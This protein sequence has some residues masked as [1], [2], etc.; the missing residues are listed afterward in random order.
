M[1]LGTPSTHT[2]PGHRFGVQYAKDVSEIE[3]RS[4]AA[5]ILG[6]RADWLTL[7]HGHYGY[8]RNP[9][10]KMTMPAPFQTYGWMIFVRESACNQPSA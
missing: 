6:V 10:N 3:A 7:K 8:E 5:R 1:N 9:P 2:P 4:W